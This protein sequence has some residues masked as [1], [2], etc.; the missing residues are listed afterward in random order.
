MPRP[1]NQQLYLDTLEALKSDTFLTKREVAKRLRTP[2]RVAYKRLVKLIAAGLV[3]RKHEAL[4]ERGGYHYVYRA[5]RSGL[6][7]VQPLYPH[8]NRQSFE[9]LA[10]CFDGYTYLKPVTMKCQPRR[11]LCH[12]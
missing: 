3:E 5:K 11:E 7:R 4:T 1:V 8:N 6:S 9:P 10:R 12:H 2:F